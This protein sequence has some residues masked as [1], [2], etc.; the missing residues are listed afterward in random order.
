MRNVSIQCAAQTQIDFSKIDACMKS[1][2][3]NQVEHQYGLQTDQLQPAHQYVPWITV[4]GIHTDAIQRDAQK[5]L[6]ALICKTY[7]VE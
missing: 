6:V 3:G 7:K 5:N 1:P 4:N 2:L